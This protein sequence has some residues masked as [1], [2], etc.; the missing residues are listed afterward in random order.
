MDK[1]KRNA[2]VITCA[3]ALIA[4]LLYVASGIVGADFIS[5]VTRGGW[6]GIPAKVYDLMMADIILSFVL[7]VALA[8]LAVVMLGLNKKASFNVALGFIIPILSIVSFLVVWN[9]ALIADLSKDFGADMSS[10]LGTVDIIA[11]VIV[12]ALCVAWFFIGE[13]E[14]V[15][16]KPKPEKARV[17][18]P[19]SPESKIAEIKELQASGAL[20][21]AEAKKFI[22]KELEK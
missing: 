18:E 13:R 12:C 6:G 22:M 5:Q 10:G 8:T 1:V 21:A 11:A 15:A 4:G 17:A 20:T 3:V 19:N 14:K 16:K 7:G 9:I 2:L